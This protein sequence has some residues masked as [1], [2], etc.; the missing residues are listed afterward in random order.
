MTVGTSANADPGRTLTIGRRIRRLAQELRRRHVF[1]V[2][3]VY[4]GV[5]FAVWQ[6]A[7]VAL[8]ALGIPEWGVSLVVVLTVLGL[9]IALVLA[10]AYDLTSAGVVRTSPSPGAGTTERGSDAPPDATPDATESARERWRR[11]QALLDQVMEVPPEE[12]RR[13]LESL[14]ADRA[15]VAEAQQLLSAFDNPGPGV[16][17]M[18]AIASEVTRLPDDSLSDGDAIGPYVLVRRLGAGGMGVVYQAKDERLGRDVALKF[19]GPFL[20]ADPVARERFLAEARIAATLDHPNVCTILDVGEAGGRPFIAMPFYEGPSLAE[21]LER[22]PLPRHRVTDIG[23]QIGRAL[24]A[25]HERGIVHRDV[26]PSNV[27]VTGDGTVKV[28]D[29]GVAKISTVNLTRTGAPLGTPSYM[30]P[31]QTRGE[32][33]DHRTDVWSLGVVLY[34]MATG[35]RPFRGKDDHAIR[36]AVLAAAPPAVDGTGADSSGLQQILE[37]CLTKDRDHRY[38]SVLEV[39][40]AIE[41]LAVDQAPSLPPASDTGSIQR[42]ERRRVTVLSALVH[43]YQRRRSRGVHRAHAAHLRLDRD[44]RGG[45]RAGAGGGSG[46]DRLRDSACP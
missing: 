7:D 15:L 32:A 46:G 42:G 10:W 17:V 30:S 23:I 14:S 24:A 13:K 33:V 29:F 26:K 3:L 39:V 35:T 9:P 21:L 11:V 38:A 34:E 6:G 28:V 41:S 27:I 22:G 12:R 19:L 1:R 5:A 40:T 44:R 8:P 20:A 37:R 45:R 31:E 16:E 25:A 2:L 4:V 43:G 18:D 36:T